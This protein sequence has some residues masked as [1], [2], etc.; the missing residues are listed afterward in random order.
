[1]QNDPKNRR[2]RTKENWLNLGLA[3]SSY[4]QISVKDWK[5]IYKRN[6]INEIKK[7]HRSQNLKKKEKKRKILQHSLVKM[8]LQRELSHKMKGSSSSY[9]RRGNKA[10]KY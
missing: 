7:W 2:D 3:F 6:N 4:F 8:A 9:I 1:M 10:K 5:F